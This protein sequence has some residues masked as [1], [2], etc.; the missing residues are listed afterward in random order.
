MARSN[1]H[2]ARVSWVVGRMNP[3]YPPN[4]SDAQPGG[5]TGSAVGIPVIPVWLFASEH[6]IVP[7]DGGGLMPQ[8]LP[9]LTCATHPSAECTV[10]SPPL[11]RH[12]GCVRQPGPA[13]VERLREDLPAILQSIVR[14]FCLII[15]YDVFRSIFPAK[16]SCRSTNWGEHP[17]G[18]PI[19]SRSQF[20]PSIASRR[21]TTNRF[22]D[23]PPSFA[24]AKVICDRSR[25]ES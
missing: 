14:I 10:F 12:Q 15:I 22:A 24:P 2:G 7:L 9:N 19:H 16:I 5:F 13:A 6:C 8:G 17:A 18:Q 4:D 21:L 23:P 20:I 11:L 3:R 25:R 1:R